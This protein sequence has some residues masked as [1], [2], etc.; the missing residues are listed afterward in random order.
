MQEIETELLKE[1]LEWF[2]AKKKKRERR[3][4]KKK[5]SLKQQAIHIANYLIA[6]QEKQNIESQKLIK[7]EEEDKY[8]CVFRNLMD[9]LKEK[10]KQCD[11]DIYLEFVFR[12][13]GGDPIYFVDGNRF[14]YEQCLIIRAHLREFKFCVDDNWPE[15]VKRKVYSFT[16][17]IIISWFHKNDDIADN[18]FVSTSKWT[19][20]LA[21]TPIKIKPN[22]CKHWISVYV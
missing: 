7:F 6:E 8:A 2:R 10:Y 20:F 12:S 11:F 5:Q 16:S 1:V 18:P 19:G 21:D 14:S 17:D 9:Q 4:L 15:E 13:H 22:D 3:L